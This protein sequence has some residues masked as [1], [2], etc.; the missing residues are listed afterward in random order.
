[1]RGGAQPV[2]DAPSTQAITVLATMGADQWG[3]L[4]KAHGRA[5]FCIHAQVQLLLVARHNRWDYT[6]VF[7]KIRQVRA[8]VRYMVLQGTCARSAHASKCGEMCAPDRARAVTHCLHSFKR[9]LEYCR[10]QPCKEEG[11]A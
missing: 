7:N 5:S 11:R 6:V 3:M 1:M 10:T 4:K 2:R 9:G 8:G